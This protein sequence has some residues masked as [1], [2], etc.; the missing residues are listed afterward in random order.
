[1]NKHSAFFVWTGLCVAVL[2]VGCGPQLPSDL[3]KLYPT[4]VTVIQDGEPLSGATVTLI[5][6]DPS[7]GWACVARTDTAGKAT[8]MTN[9][10]YKGAPEGTYKVTVSKQEVEQGDNPFAD[11]PDPAVDQTAYQEWVMKNE[12][13]IAAAQRR[14]PVTYDLVD[15]KFSSPTQTTLELTIT[16]GKNQHSLDVGKSN[17]TVYRDEK[18][19]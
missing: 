11:A 18:S 10:M 15:P 4:V 5:N 2:C 8:I 19:P 1:M 3:P 13:R 9:G 17:R 6:A 7:G 16:P 12:D 14:Q